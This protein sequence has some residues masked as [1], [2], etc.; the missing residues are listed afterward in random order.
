M[1]L[2]ACAR[3]GATTRSSRG[4][5][6]RDSGLRGQGWQNTVTNTDGHSSARPTPTRLHSSEWRT[7][8]R[9]APSTLKETEIKR[10][11]G[12]LWRRQACR[13]LHAFILYF[14]DDS[15]EFDS[16]SLSAPPEFF[17]DRNANRGAL[18]ISGYRPTGQLYRNTRTTITAVHYGGAK[19]SADLLA[20]QGVG[21]EYPRHRVP[22]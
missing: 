8:R 11:F 7:L 3:R 22:R 12:R 19:R 17:A 9:S 4:N 2:A 5:V 20:K 6:P 10:I 18:D 21:P 1:L 15:E 13:R 16:R 14:K